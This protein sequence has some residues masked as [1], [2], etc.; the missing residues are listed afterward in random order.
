MKLKTGE[1]FEQLI[2]ESKGAFVLF[3]QWSN[4]EYSCFVKIDKVEWTS[5]KGKDLKDAL[6]ETIGFFIHYYGKETKIRYL[7][8]KDHTIN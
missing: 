7:Q 4:G 1:L 8:N 2:K 5:T 3:H 6:T